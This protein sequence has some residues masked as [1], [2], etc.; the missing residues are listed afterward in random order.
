MILVPEDFLIS[1]P[2]ARAEAMLA[3]GE[4]HEW[5]PRKGKARLAARQPLAEFL[6]LRHND[7]RHSLAATQPVDV[8]AIAT[9]IDFPAKASLA[10]L[11]ALLTDWSLAGHCHVWAGKKKG[12]LAFWNRGPADLAPSLCGEKLLTPKQFLQALK[13]SGVADPDR[14]L[15]QLLSSRQLVEFAPDPKKPKALGLL[16]PAAPAPFLAPLILLRDRL[17]AAGVPAATLQQILTPADPAAEILSTLIQLEPQ[18]DAHFSLTQ[19]RRKLPHLSKEVFDQACLQLAQSGK[20]YLH[21]HDAPFLLTPAQRD[22]LVFDGQ[23]TY[24]IAIS[25]QTY[26]QS[27]S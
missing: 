22:E 12:S 26:A 6:S 7:I 15:A 8:E 24:F 20:V 9:A 2:K 5:P 1:L 27:V 18:P 13:K 14:L 21:Y 10:P 4:W 3:S 16:N 17:L 19:L 11:I 23:S 25:R